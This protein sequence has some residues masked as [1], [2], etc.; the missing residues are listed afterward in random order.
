MSHGPFGLEEETLASVPDCCAVVNV[1]LISMRASANINARLIF[2][3]MLVPFARRCPLIRNFES[4]L[5]VQ[6]SKRLQRYQMR[7]AFAAHSECGPGNVPAEDIVPH[8]RFRVCCKLRAYP[9]SSKGWG[10]SWVPLPLVLTGCLVLVRSSGLR[11]RPR[12]ALTFEIEFDRSAD[13][14]LQGC[15]VDRFALVEVYG[16]PDVAL[17]A[18]IEE[19]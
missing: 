12:L 1:A 6:P 19:S 11:L 3:F 5:Y 2:I 13:E 4:L 7:S 16:A 15:F 8:S 17:K 18:R 14:I 10:T 9:D